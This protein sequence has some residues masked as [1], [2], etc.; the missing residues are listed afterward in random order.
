MPLGGLSLA[1]ATCRCRV[2]GARKDR[3]TP[4]KDAKKVPITY[5]P[6]I[7]FI[8][9]SPPLFFLAIAFITKKKTSTGATPFN[10][11]TNRSPKMVTTG[12]A[13]GT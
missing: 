5:K 4:T 8:F 11:F 13:F 7:G 10:A 3:L 6:I 1:S 12:T 9:A 2:V